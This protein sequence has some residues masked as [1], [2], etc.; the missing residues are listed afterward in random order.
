ML[1]NK[2]L[3]VFFTGIGLATTLG[4]TEILEAHELKSKKTAII[5]PEIKPELRTL[6]QWGVPNLDNIK[7]YRT[8]EDIAFRVNGKPTITEY[9]D[10]AGNVYLRNVLNG[11]TY[12]LFV[13]KSAPESVEFYFSSTDNGLFQNLSPEGVSC[14]PAEYK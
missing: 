10:V 6:Q 1:I 3:A 8:E 5:K 7:P 9:F 13:C 11:R 14:S 12:I 2:N 4:L